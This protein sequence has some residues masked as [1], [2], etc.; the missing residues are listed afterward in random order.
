MVDSRTTLRDDTGVDDS[1]TLNE[2]V[3]TDFL[4]VEAFRDDS[5]GALIATEIRRDTLDDDILQGPLDACAADTSVTLLGLTYTLLAGTTEYQ[6]QNDAPISG[7]TFCSAANSGGF[8]IKIRDDLAP[9]GIA[10]EAELED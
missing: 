4:E 8:F 5:S 10:D 6:D 7:T 9:D 2:I 3:A 1:L